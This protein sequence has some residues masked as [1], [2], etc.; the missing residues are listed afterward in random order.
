VFPWLVGILRYGETAQD[1]A[2]RP[3]P[4]N[5]Q[6]LVPALTILS[7]AN[8]KFTA[9]AQMRLDDPGKGHDRYLVG[10]DFAF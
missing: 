8:I 9:E 5:Q 2:V 6:F 10:I 3:D 4:T 7:R 1:F